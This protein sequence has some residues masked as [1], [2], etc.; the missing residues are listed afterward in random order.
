M[1]DRDTLS[2]QCG[3]NSLV[4]LLLLPLCPPSLRWFDYTF[5]SCFFCWSVLINARRHA[6]K[7]NIHDHTNPCEL[8]TTKN[9]QLRVLS[10][11]NLLFF[12]YSDAISQSDQLE[13]LRRSIPGEPDVDYPIYRSPPETEFSCQSRATGTKTH[14]QRHTKRKKDPK[15]LFYW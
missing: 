11:L 6:T 3:L 13:N 15:C 10:A 14:T 12:C 7:F 5:S 8:N 4:L 1:G 9:Q 2:A